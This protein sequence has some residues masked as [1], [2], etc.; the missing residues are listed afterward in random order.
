MV[1]EALTPAAAPGV[2][3]ASLLNASG[4]SAAPSVV[5]RDPELIKLHDL[6]RR[7]AIGNISV[8]LLGETGSGKEIFAEVIH[9]HS[10]RHAKPLL[11]LNCAALT[12][13]L[14]ESELFGH[15][16]GAF[17]GADKAKPGLFEAADGGT[18]LLDEIGELPLALQAKLLRVLQDKLVM[19]IG[20]LEPRSI[21]VRFIAATNR[22]LQ[23]EVAR[24]RFRADLL[25]RLNGVTLVV[26]PLRQRLS[27]LEELAALFL[28]RAAA[29][30]GQPAPRLSEAALAA[31]RRY[32]WPGNIRELSNVIERAVLVA[33]G[34]PEVT[35]EH[36]PFDASANPPVPAVANEAARSPAVDD[37]RQRIV[38]A[39]AKHQGNQTYAAQELGIARSTLVAK[40][41]AYRLPRPRKREMR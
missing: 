32:S 10:S 3:D 33:G 35:A 24:G 21:D 19:R 18:V 11:R 15:E 30:L 1:R 16:R 39:L 6:A 22:Q 4:D 38:D 17:T 20:A 26:P 34:A 29:S 23:S 12:E 36:F 9:R 13:S 25:Y 5:V 14:L 27:E 40:M 37:E 41:V 31:L 7:V 2:V 8:L 28:R